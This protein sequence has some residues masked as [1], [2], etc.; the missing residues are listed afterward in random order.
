MCWRSARATEV[1][2]EVEAEMEKGSKT[3]DMPPTNQRTGARLNAKTEDLHI[4]SYLTGFL[5]FHR[6]AILACSN[7][8]RVW[9]VESLHLAPRLRKS[10]SELKKR[11]ALR[12][13][14]PPQQEPRNPH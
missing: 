14:D 2:V 12:I 11:F 10:L 7:E 9:S 5:F 6:T 8:Y 1:E 3:L 13:P 4:P